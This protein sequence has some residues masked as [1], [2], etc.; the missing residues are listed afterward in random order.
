[1]KNNNN[2]FK[3]F[4]NKVMSEIKS[5]R[6]K[7]RSKYIF[8]AEKFGLNSALILSTV[9]AILFFSLVL[10]YIR[11]TD[12]LEYLSFGKDGILAFLESFPYLLVVSF[13]LLL[14]ITGY[15]ITKTEW[16]HKK[17]FKY[18]VIG[19]IT[20]VLII[21]SVIAYVG[22]AEQI[23]YQIF[24]NRMPGIFFKPFIGRMMGPHGRGVAGKVYEVNNDYLILET[25]HGFE[26][27]SLFKLSCQKTTCKD[28]FEVNQFIIAIGKRADNIFVVDKIRITSEDNFSPIIKRRIHRRFD[29]FFNNHLDGTQSLPPNL[30]NFDESTNKCVEKCFNETSRP[31]RC[32]SKCIK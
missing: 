11:A 1:M 21:G 27:I 29:S 2:N 28:Q 8:L 24:D 23:E 15:L 19:L 20:L 12:N 14:L 9:L 17:P 4:E 6:V 30:L 3:K 31:K 25:M 13:I 5:G 32:F 7:L 22:I 16:S 10:F 26:K 18:F